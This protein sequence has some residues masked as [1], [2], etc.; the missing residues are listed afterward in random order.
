MRKYFGFTLIEVMI[1]LSL[2]AVVMIPLIQWLL[3]AQSTTQFSD[4]LSHIQENATFT[5]QAITRDIYHAGFSVEDLIVASGYESLGS[6]RWIPELPSEIQG[7]VH[8]TSDVLVLMNVWDPDESHPTIYYYLDDSGRVN[9]KGESIIVLYRHSSLGREEYVEGLQAFK[10]HF[11]LD[12]QNDGNVDMFVT[13][14]QVNNWL[15]V[16]G[17][18][19]ELMFNS[20]SGAALADPIH[21]PFFIYA[22]F[23]NRV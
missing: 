21:K 20:L 12:S 1:S 23:R 7:Q 19:L 3:M 8:P 5:S 17:L 14:S 22:G 6:N 9:H 16:S 15:L 4:A 11:S 13:P 10:L 18:E 2:G